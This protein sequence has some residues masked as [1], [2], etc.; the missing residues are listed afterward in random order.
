MI[1]IDREYARVQ[2]HGRGNGSGDSPLDVR[3]TPWTEAG[4]ASDPAMHFRVPRNHLIR[5]VDGFGV[6]WRE[7]PPL[8]ERLIDAFLERARSSGAALVNPRPGAEHYVVKMWRAITGH[9][10]LPERLKEM[11]REGRGQAGV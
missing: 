7:A 3:L 9:E 11:A 10:P 8:R 5:F 2:S 1:I 6:A 4:V